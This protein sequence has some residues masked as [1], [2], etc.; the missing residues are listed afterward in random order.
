M[1][2][3]GAAT[4]GPP[5]SR[6][7]ARDLG[8]RIGLLPSGP[9]DSIVD[10]PGVRVGHATVWRD[11][12]APPHG[13]GT[14]RTGVTVVVPFTPAELLEAPVAA[15]GAV[16]N[17]AGEVTGLQ[18][19]LEW[20]VLETPI[21]LTSTMAVGRVYDG[22]VEAIAGAPDFPA[23]GIIIPVVGECDDGYLNHARRVQVD[24]GTVRAALDAVRGSE[25]GA[26]PN[27]AVGA[28]TGMI[29]HE[30]KGGIG[31]ASRVVAAARRGYAR[32][33]SPANEPRPSFTVGVLALTNHGRLERLTIDGVPVG[34]TLRA[35]GWPEA[36]LAAGGVARRLE[37]DAGSCIVLVA[38]DAPLDPRQLTRLA[39]RA[40][41]GLARAGSYA[42]HGSGDLFVAFSTGT[43]IVRD[44]PA[45][46]ERTAFNDEYLDPLLAA[47]VEAT[48]EAVVD[49][50][51]GADTVV[52]RDGHAAPGLPLE[53]TMELLR[54]TGR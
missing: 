40:G 2:G 42:G 48:E 25:A 43:R 30:L 11:E 3:R 12:A 54:E 17:G 36:G 32:D 10:V 16:L 38:T 37:G 53:R 52:G 24:A 27:G 41:M 51:M 8:I 22:L 13:R 7:R 44:G 26:V 21:A 20:G 45:L 9:T 29:C 50:L 47:V 15:G 14:A 18:S 33:M 39:R 19:I 31:G 6:G 4:S 23:D 28:G 46:V 49:S 35:E 5:A 1:A 34:R